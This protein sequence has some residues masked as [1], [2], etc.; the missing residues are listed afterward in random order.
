MM[1]PGGISAAAVA[2]SL[3]PNTNTCTPMQ[4]AEIGRGPSRD[5]HGEGA[6]AMLASSAAA[7]RVLEALPPG[8][9]LLPRV[10]VR[11]G[12]V[13]PSTQM[14]RLD[15]RALNQTFQAAIRMGVKLQNLSATSKAAAAGANAQGVGGSGSTRRVLPTNRLVI[16]DRLGEL[17]APTTTACG[18]GAGGRGRLPGGRRGD[19]ATEGGDAWGDSEGEDQ[20][21]R[22]A[23]QGDAGADSDDDAAS[24]SDTREVA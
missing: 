22:G 6:N 3:G 21:A 23:G 1:D 18:G 24:G 7:G 13:D 19:R 17:L 10:A 11:G 8:V 5:Q 14:R 15:P 9:S 12:V 16:R 20:R 2:S 4:P